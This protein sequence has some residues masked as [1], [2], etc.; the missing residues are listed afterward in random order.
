MKLVSNMI[1]GDRSRPDM[2]APVGLGK[3]LRNIWLPKYNMI[4]I[5]GSGKKSILH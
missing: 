2:D 4:S 3:K 5:I 1:R